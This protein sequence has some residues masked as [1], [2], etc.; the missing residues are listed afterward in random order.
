MKRGGI[1]TT[2]NFIWLV[3]FI[4]AVIVFIIIVTMK[5]GQDFSKAGEIITN[6]FKR[7]VPG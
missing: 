2:E 7:I 1:V 6:L 5:Y 3:I 4:I